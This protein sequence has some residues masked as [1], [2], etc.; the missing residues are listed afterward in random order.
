MSVENEGRRSTMTCAEFE[1][2]FCDY[3]DGLLREPEKTAIEGHLHACTACAE[4]AQEI[5]G[6]VAFIGQ[7]E[8]VEPPAELV[9][10]ILHDIPTVRVKRERRTWF[11]R[12]FGGIKDAVLQPRFAMGMAMTMLSIPL[13]AY[14]MGI[15]P[16]QMSLSDLNPAKIW[17]AVEDRAHRVWDRAVKYYD[18]MR[19]VIEIQSRLKQW[20][21][22]D[23]AQQQRLQQQKNSTAPKERQK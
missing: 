7:A 19:L 22:Q 8:K 23:Q 14:L 3:V 1:I 17:T 18:N 12:F 2:Q 5:R 10:R 11:G 20:S 21:E 15:N 16:R 13:L 9:T 4:L 6:A